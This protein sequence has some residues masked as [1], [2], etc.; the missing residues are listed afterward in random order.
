MDRRE[1]LKR[2]AALSVGAG[3]L[4]LP[5]GLRGLTRLANAASYPDLV[6]VR[7]GTPEAMFDRGIKSIGG[8]SRFVK[9]GQRVLL[10]PNIS[11]DATPDGAA[12]TSPGLIATLVKHCLDAGAAKVIVMDHSI[13][14]WKNSLQ[15]SGVHAAAIGAGAVYAPAESEKY[16]SNVA[17]NGR[18]LKETMI[19]EAILECDVL[20]SVPVLKHHGG[21]G[22]S[23]AA[24][25]LMG[26]VWNR[27]AYHSGG[28][29]SC[30]AD[31]LTVR[32]PDLSIVDANR[33][34]TKNGPRGGSPSDIVEMNSLLIS[35]DIVAIDTAASM[36]LGRKPG[37][38]EHIR[39]AAEAGLGRMDLSQLNIERIKI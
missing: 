9:S 14:Y 22:V 16:Y 19:H 6:A 37:E 24:K 10:K 33:V 18:R 38:I 11:W 8:I 25:N 30:I 29:Q 17:V 1:F 13:E 27:M 20:I 28:L 32:K 4:F 21:A 7:G 35:Q 15:N 2:S 3:L 31:F 34:I 39:L 23:I 26:C 12:N 36:M 5:K